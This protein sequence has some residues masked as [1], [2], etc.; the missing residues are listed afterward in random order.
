MTA[1]ALEALGQRIRMLIGRGR[2]TTGND[3]GA[4]QQ[5]QV[6]LAGVETGDNRPRVAEFGFTSMPPAGADAVVVFLSGD[7]SAGVVVATNHQQS[8]P[9]GMKPGETMVYSQDGKCVYFSDAGIVVDAKGQPVTV[10]NASVATIQAE[11][12]IVADTPL[13]QCTGDIQDNSGSNSRTMKEMRDV[14]NTH[15]H[16]V[17]NVQGGSSTVTTDHP[18]QTE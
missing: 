12:K 5:L 15:D 18:N 10:Q 2:I 11:T 6:Q 8:R 13:F 4:V 3:T 14:F 16:A 1:A 7:R 9:R 17:R